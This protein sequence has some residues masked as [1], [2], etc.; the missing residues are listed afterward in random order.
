MFKVAVNYAWDDKIQPTLEL[1]AKHGGFVDGFK[2]VGPAGGNPQMTL[3]FFSK[4]QA[5]AYLRERCPDD[6][7]QFCESRVVGPLATVVALL[8]DQVEV[9]RLLLEFHR[10][11][12][13]AEHY[14][15][16][17]FRSLCGLFD[18]EISR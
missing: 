8:P 13:P 9:L 15:N 10:D 16:E 2:P 14:D 12:E 3:R 1:I 11:D 5:V 4:P 17:H 18:V 6:S 7:A